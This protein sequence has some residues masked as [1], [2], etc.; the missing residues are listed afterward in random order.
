MGTKNNGGGRGFSEHANRDGEAQTDTGITC[1][2]AHDVYC[3]FETALHISGILIMCFIRIGNGVP[4]RLR[5]AKYGTTVAGGP[6]A[7]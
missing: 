7:F 1:R 3:T 5:L 2:S 6:T 4:K